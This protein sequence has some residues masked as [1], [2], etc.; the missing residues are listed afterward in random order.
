MDYTNPLATRLGKITSRHSLSKDAQAALAVVSKRYR[1]GYW[2]GGETSDDD[3]S[4]SDDDDEDH[5]KASHRPRSLISTSL[6]TPATRL[7]FTQDLESD[8]ASGSHRFLNAFTRLDIALDVLDGRLHEMVDRC[9]AVSKQV[10][11]V[12]SGVEA[13]VSRASGLQAQQ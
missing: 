13:V 10:E 7:Q 12:N 4:D 3:D 11:A 6:D 8:L 5:D 9:E 1:T 2:M